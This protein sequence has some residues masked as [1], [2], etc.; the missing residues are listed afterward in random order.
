MAGLGELP[1]IVLVEIFRSLD[2]LELVKN[3]ALTNKRFHHIVH[4][5]SSLWRHISADH[6]LELSLTDLRRILKHS[7][8]FLEFLIPCATLHFSSADID[9]I[10]V[11]E[12]CNARCLYWL[13]LT[14]CRLSTLCFLPFLT[15]IEILNLSE[16]KN[17][18]SEDFE[19][20]SSLK[21]LDQLY[22]SYTNITPEAIVSICEPLVLTVLDVAGIP[23]NI[24]Y[25][26]RILKPELLFFHL[27][28]ESQEDEIWLKGIIT[29]HYKDLSLHIIRQ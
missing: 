5:N 8:A 14:E 21:K 15:N 24:Q 18:V 17:L 12:L 11:N 26:V 7:V 27:T 28:L 3:I 19:V 29:G 22:L 20:I 1:D 10:F 23:L 4:Q 16:C 9:F 2:L 25:I 13:D 6:Q